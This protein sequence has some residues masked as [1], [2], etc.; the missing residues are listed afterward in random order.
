MIIKK[1]TVAP[2][3]TNF[4]KM[5]NLN[6]NSSTLTLIQ[7]RTKIYVNKRSVTPEKIYVSSVNVNTPSKKVW[8]MIRK[9]PERNVASLMHHLKDNNVTPVTDRVE[10]ANTLGAARPP[11]ITPKSSHQSRPTRKSK[12][13][14]LKQTKIF[15]TIRR[16]R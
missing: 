14:I 9:M 1:T 2:T 6:V 16:L 12:R 8:D 11:T 13:S 15:V 10:I 7:A 4:S 5:K 3:S